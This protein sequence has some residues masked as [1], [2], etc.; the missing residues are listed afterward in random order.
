MYVHEG[1]DGDRGARNR[2]AVCVTH[3][4]ELMHVEVDGRR[5]RVEARLVSSRLENYLGEVGNCNNC[6][7]P[8]RCRTSAAKPSSTTPP[9]HHSQPPSNYIP[10]PPSPRFLHKQHGHK[11]RNLTA[12]CLQPSL[13]LFSPAQQAAPVP[14]APNAPLSTDL[15]Q[16]TVDQVIGYSGRCASAATHSHR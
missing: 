2:A 13:L 9:S 8:K 3:Y 6:N 12:P 5:R 16:Q 11:A 1:R 14:R 10:F 4:I 15:S 7:E